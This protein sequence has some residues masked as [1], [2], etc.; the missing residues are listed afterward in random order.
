[1][2][3]I[4][5]VIPRLDS[6]KIASNVSQRIDAGAS[7]A[8]SAYQTA[9]TFGTCIAPQALKLTATVMDKIADVRQCFSLLRV[10]LDISNSMNRCIP[11]SIYSANPPKSRLNSPSYP[12]D[13][14][15]P[16]LLLRDA[17]VV[18]QVLVHRDQRGAPW[19]GKNT[20]RISQCEY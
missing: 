6:N 8:P 18:E 19:A 5:A 14:P 4:D 7:V 12:S 2:R 20:G 16:D 10:T 13:E 17:T 9:K 1:M 15:Q 11:Y 3:R